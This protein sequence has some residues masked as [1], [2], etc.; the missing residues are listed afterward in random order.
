MTSEN[1]NTFTKDTAKRGIVLEEAYQQIKRMFYLNELVPGQK[2]VYNDLAKVAF[3]VHH[4]T[5]VPPEDTSVNHV[6]V[7][8]M[9]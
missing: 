4:D 8:H 1:K 2:L 5:V 9:I 7:Q 6:I 3:A